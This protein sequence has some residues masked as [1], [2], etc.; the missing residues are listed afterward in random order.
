MILEPN[1]KSFIWEK[2]EAE[3]SYERPTAREGHSMVYL[4]DKN[5]YLI[6]GGISN[7]RYSDIHTLNPSITILLILQ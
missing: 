4:S 1:Q 2:I 6:F 3:K 7:T 5:K